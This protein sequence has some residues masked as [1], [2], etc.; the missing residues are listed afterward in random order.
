[1][2]NQPA[3]RT[4]PHPCARMASFMPS[5]PWVAITQPPAVRILIGAS[6]PV[7]HILAVAIGAETDFGWEAA[8]RIEA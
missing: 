7:V 5:L 2:S 4:I 6:Q 3:S 8:R 1:M